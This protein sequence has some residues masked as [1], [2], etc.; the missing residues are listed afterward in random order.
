[1]RAVGSPMS[2]PSKGEAFAIL[3]DHLRYAQEQA[4]TLG[5]LAYSDQDHTL[6]EAWLQVSENLRRAQDI[7]MRLA[8]KGLH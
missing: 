5:H 4:A 2:V 7:I 1:M 6:G 3:L 8:T